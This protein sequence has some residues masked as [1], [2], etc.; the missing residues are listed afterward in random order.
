VL[1]AQ[2]P[3]RALGVDEH[4]TDSRA[5]AEHRAGLAVE[6][7]RAA[8]EGRVGQQAAA[9]RPLAA[10]AALALLL[11]QLVAEPALGEAPQHEG[12]RAAG[13]LVTPPLLLPRRRHDAQQPHGHHRSNARCQA[14]FN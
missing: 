9:D 11:D 5:A 2:A 12:A 14:H 13:R 7:H 1:R 10:V 8:V 4:E 6:D 3:A